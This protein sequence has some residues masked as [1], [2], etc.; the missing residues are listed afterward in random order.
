MRG[1]PRLLGLAL[2][3]GLLYP[4]SS[5]ARAPEPS[6]RQL[7]EEV[8]GSPAC[9]SGI[10]SVSAWSSGGCTNVELTESRDG[11]RWRWEVQPTGYTGPALMLGGD[12]SRWLCRSRSVESLP[13]SPAPELLERRL[14]Q[15]FESYRWA[16]LGPDSVAGRPTWA[17]EARPSHPGGLRNRFWI[18]QEFPVILRREK[19][20]PRGRLLY[21]S[22]FSSIR[23]HGRLDEALFQRPAAQERPRPAREALGFEPRLPARPPAGF[24]EEAARPMDPLPGG[25]SASP[26]HQAS[27]TDGLEC[28][29]LFQVPGQAPLALDTEAEGIPGELCRARR[30]VRSEGQLLSWSDGQRSF[31]LVSAVP[32]ETFASLVAQLRPERPSPRG[33][34]YYLQRV[35]RGWRRLLG[36]FRADARGVSGGEPGPS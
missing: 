25:A 31:L 1:R 19:L 27:Y 34:L 9:Y 24:I 33:L 26:G 21:R 13:S 11:S 16:F 28:V 18:D 32:P 35:Q 7:M 20:D 3:L 14:Q 15:A 22:V 2:G 29:S 10:R 5:W 12:R 8:I 6:P 30:S 36:W 4:L 17:L 23:F